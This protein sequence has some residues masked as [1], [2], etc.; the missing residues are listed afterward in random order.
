MK[1]RYF[2]RISEG[3]EILWELRC[4]K[5]QN[6]ATA[7]Q[8]KKIMKD[9]KKVRIGMVKMAKTVHHNPREIKKTLP[10]KNRQAFVSWDE[11]I[12]SDDEFYKT[13]VLSHLF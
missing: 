2:Y 11:R 1:F 10:I 6:E 3:D 13:M 8:N 9:I 12:T 7:E 5:K 4:M